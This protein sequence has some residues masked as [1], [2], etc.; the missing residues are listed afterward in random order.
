MSWRV[1]L[2]DLDVGED[3][4]A[5]VTDVLRKKWLT[6]GEVTQRFE[7]EF[8][9]LVGVKHAFAV[10]NCT[11]A[12]ELAYHC[13]GVQP[14]DEVVMPALT[15]VA[16][17]NAAV[18]LGARPVFVDVTSA[19][20]LTLSV[21][22][23]AEKVGP[24]TRAIAVMHYGGYLCD[25]DGVARVAAERGIPIVEDC[26]HAPGA[27]DANGRQAGAFGALGCFS[28]FSNKNLTTGEG[29][30]ITTDRDDLAE[31]VRLLRSH[32][33]TTLTLERH[34]GHSF[35]YDVVEP[36]YNFRLDEIRSAMGLVQLA[37]LAAGNARRAVLT[38]RY[39]QQLDGARGI[40]LPFAARGVGSSHHLMV[41]VLDE[42]VARE[43]FMTGLRD[44]G[45][46]SSI[47]YPPVHRFSYYE[48]E[49]PGAAAGLPRTEALRERLVT[50]PLYPTMRD[51]DV[52]LVAA[53]VRRL[54]EQ[55]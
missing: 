54:L 23:L 35:S 4:I 38:Q 13:V 43:K 46:Q 24:R 8:A 39:R 45:I 42:G 47:H 22:D 31:R 36:G 17:A 34:R 52:D 40:A 55:A 12:L 25:M 11:A 21:E 41:A 14:G 27:N 15:F 48:R 30:M 2:S 1:P 26:A 5:A 3:E 16:T 53:T 29:G 9:A 19:D 18:T 20:D 10:A 6:M 37:K 44:A 49:Y 50:L 51:E 33:M 7:R 28:F 32:G